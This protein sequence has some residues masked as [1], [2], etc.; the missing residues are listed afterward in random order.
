MLHRPGGR[1]RA[2]NS[3]AS[4]AGSPGARGSNG[5]AWLG[6]LAIRQRIRAPL[7]SALPPSR[8]SQAGTP[9]RSDA[10][11]SRRVAVKSRLAGLPHSS[12]ITAP[13]APHLKPSSIAHSAE[14][15]SR[16][17]TW[18]S[19][20]QPIPGGWTRPASRI[21]IRSCTHSSGLPGSNCA[22]RN[23]AQPPSRGWAA[24]SSL[25]VGWGGRGKRQYSGAGRNPVWAPALGP[26]EVILR[27]V[28]FAGAQFSAGPKGATRLPPATRDKP[29]AT[30]LATFMFY[31]C[32]S[33][34]SRV[35]RVNG[36]TRRVVVSLKFSRLGSLQTR[37][38]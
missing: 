37:L 8:T 32:S 16:A 5:W 1:P 14:R 34:A 30:R 21:A 36:A 12:P 38:A 18:M 29:L 22:S 33:T 11:A 3:S 25:S 23:P 35:A 13:N 9:E 6:Q 15:A 31:F 17:V 10:T 4:H 26:T 2:R 20:G 19:S 7:K 24:N 28:P 27:W